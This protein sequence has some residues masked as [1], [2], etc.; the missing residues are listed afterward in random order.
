VQIKS[1]EGKAS[2]KCNNLTTYACGGGGT[3]DAWQEIVKLGLFFDI[4]TN[5][6]TKV[7]R[8]KLRLEQP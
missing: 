6:S 8:T 7:T 3:A 2:L 4:A 1:L 5:T